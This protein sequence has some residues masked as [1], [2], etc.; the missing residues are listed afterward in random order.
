MRDMSDGRVMVF[1]PAP[2]LTVTIEQHH[3]EPEL[4]V[5]PGGQGIW[6]TRMITSLGARVTLCAA[7]GG[8]VGRVL[9]P[10]L[11]L[12]GVTLRLVMREHGSG[13]YVHDRRG[14][15]RQEIAERPGT[16]LS[17]H[18]LDELYNLTLAEGLRAGIA[19]LSGPAH[20][21][22]IKPEVYG[23]L[24]ADLRSNGC[25]VIADLC[26]R[27]LAAVLEA[28]ITVLKISHEELIA[29]GMAPDGST[30][31]LVK[32]LIQLHENGAETVL[33]SRA[34]EGAL[35]LFDGE[36]YTVALPRLTPAEHRGAGDSMTAGVAATLAHGGHIEEAVR[37]GA[38]A[39][40]LNVTRHGLGTGHV[41][42]V[43]VLTE[44][45]RLTPIEKA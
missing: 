29:D 24:A 3:D 8:E 44:R 40:A 11:A 17:R 35:A 26:S 5:H 36:I 18:E 42:A 33:V 12:P 34:D 10:L 6:Q 39:G 14:G 7:A 25:K 19:I 43:R 15:S 27:H 28:G 37:T 2:Q 38:A 41:D 22:V 32:A 4:H 31:S 23:R 9:A 21:S 13:W 20:P 45:V 30:G 16:P 1:A